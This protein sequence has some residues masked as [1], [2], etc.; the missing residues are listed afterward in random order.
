MDFSELITKRQ[1]ERQYDARPV[2][3][4]KIMQC[5]EAAR[6]APSACNAQPWKFIVVD[7][8][9]LK[10]QLATAITGMGMNKFV[11]EASAIVAIALEK[12]NALSKIGSVLK[13]KEY[14]LM[15]IGIVAA[16]FCLQ[17]TDLGLGTCIVGWFDE[18]KVRQLLQVPNK[19]RIPLLLTVGYTTAE[20]RKKQ[21]KEL[22]VMYSANKY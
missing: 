17:A 6:M 13:G 20:L 15:D 10:K 18:K 5:I 1:S 22:E 7:E 21:R 14:I 19:K 9:E 8:P 4:E 16:H 12:P 2:E 3:P 11:G